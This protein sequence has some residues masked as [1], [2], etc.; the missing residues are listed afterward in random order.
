M[1]YSQLSSVVSNQNYGGNNF[2]DSKLCFINLKKNNLIN[3]NILCKMMSRDLKNR[4][5]LKERK[6][7][8]SNSTFQRMHT[9]MKMDKAIGS[10]KM[11]QIDI[12]ILI[13]LNYTILYLSMTHY[14]LLNLTI[15][16]F[17]ERNTFHDLCFVTR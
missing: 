1:L 7:I 6:K 11:Q 10:I 12:Y 5:D 4:A 9:L 3:V 8:T 13:L 15:V 17:Q 16:T 2:L 14:D